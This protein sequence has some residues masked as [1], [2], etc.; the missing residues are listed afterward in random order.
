M[1]MPHSTLSNVCIITLAVAGVPCMCPDAEAQLPTGHRGTATPGNRG[2]R[3]PITF[4]ALRESFHDPDMIYAPFMFWFWDEPVDADKAAEMARTMLSQN[5][6]PGYAHARRSMVGTASLPDEE[7]LSDKWFGAFEAA[8]HEAEA[9]DNY[10]GYCDEYWWPSL[11][12]HGRVLAAHPELKAQ[13]LAWQTIDARACSKV[14]VPESFFAVAARLDQALAPETETLAAPVR[15]GHWIWHRTVSDGQTCNFRK[16]FEVPASAKLKAARVRITADNRFRLYLDGVEIGTGNNWK[17]VAE[18]G[19]AEFLTPGHHVLAVEATNEAGP[20]GLL[21][22]LRAELANGQSLEVVSDASWHVAVDRASGWEQ[23][24]FDAEG[25]DAAHEIAPADAAP[26]NL[27]ATPGERHTP[28]PIRSE[29][30]RVI[31][32]GSPFVWQVPQDG[33]WRVYA[34]T[35]YFHPGADGSPVNYLDE[36]LAPAFIEIALEPYHRRVGERMGKTIPGCF[37]DNEGDYGWKLAWSET[38]DERYRGAYRRDIRLWMPLLADE[39]VEGVYARAR[40]EWFDVV[41][42]LYAE[43]MGAVSEW[44]ERHGMYCTVHFWEEGLSPQAQ[45]VG[46]HLKLLRAYTMPGQDCLGLKALHIHDF[47]EPQ[48]VAEFEGRRCMTEFMGAGAFAGG[49]PWATFTPALLKQCT[50]AAFAWGASHAIPHGVFMTRELE[51]NPWPPD[52][53]TENPAFPHLHLWADFVRRASFINSHGHQAA[54]VLLLNPMDSVWALSGADIFD[55]D[56]PVDLWRHPDDR[57]AGKRVNHINE[58]YTKAM[59]DLAAGRIEFLVGDRHYLRQMR[60]QDARL[61]RD[62]YAFAAVILPPMDILPLDVAE[63]ILAFAKGGGAVYALGELPRGSTNHGMDDERIQQLMATLSALPSFAACPD[64]ITPLIESSAPRLNRHVQFIN[65]AFAM[66]QHHRRIADR[67]FFWL[68]NN[69]DQ[70]QTSQVRIPG[71]AGQASVWDCE[72]GRVDA[73][74]SEMRNGNTELQLAFDPYEAYWLVIDGHQ[75]NVMKPVMTRQSG[76]EAMRITGEWTARLDPAAQPVLEYRVRYP[77]E[78]TRAAGLP[79]E[80]KPWHDWGVLDQ[81][82]A[83]H[84][85]YERSIELPDLVSPVILDLGTVHDMAEVWVNGQ[86]VGSRLWGPYR[87]DVSQAVRPGTNVVR[88]RVGNLV[89]NNYGDAQ[90]SGLIGPVVVCSGS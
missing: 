84:V 44:H 74:A 43:T 87:F 83:G 19:V 18:Y 61:V 78:L 60:V 42:D 2:Q 37:V 15:L 25:W 57:P 8:L 1:I 21:F 59:E 24:R 63:T 12:A 16:D 28:R 48:S 73:I 41:S 90:P 5:I 53:Y 64:G 32:A 55:V 23:P 33:D 31:G 71:L 72:T 26:W 81:R 14:S 77:E 39:D 40:W 68:V 3:M 51:G 6:S 79:I 11:Q 58:V 35:K 54:D 75:A 80:L 85:D 52:W 62:E 13:S 69:T 7:W 66:L 4:E 45:A 38:L 10:F 9:R 86:R 22:G 70:T 20:A 89:N 30:L 67:D 34:F 47:K 49:R 36:R 50:N 56:A 76:P 82:F 27:S 17:F 46:D 29:T 65:G 88:V